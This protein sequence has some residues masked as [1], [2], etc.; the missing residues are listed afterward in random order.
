MADGSK[1][2]GEYHR[3]V[4]TRCFEGEGLKLIRTPIKAEQRQITAAIHYKAEPIEPNRIPP[5]LRSERLSEDN[6]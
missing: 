1:N 2:P 5:Q 4:T 6:K 3:I